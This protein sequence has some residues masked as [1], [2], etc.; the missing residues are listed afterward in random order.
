MLSGLGHTLVH[1]GMAGLIPCQAHTHVV[2]LIL[3]S[4]V[5]GRQPINV[6]LSHQCCSLLPFLSLKLSFKNVKKYAARSYIVESGLSCF[7][8]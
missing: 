4:C 8:N 1:Q 2:G 6:A 3:C 5:C 7:L